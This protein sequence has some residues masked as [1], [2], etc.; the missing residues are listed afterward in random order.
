MTTNTD[1]P[2]IYRGLTIGIVGVL[3][4]AI[5]PI[6]L[7]RLYETGRIS[8]EGIGIAICIEFIAMALG[9]MIGAKVLSQGHM[10]VRLTLV[11]VA[12]AAANVW[13]PVATGNLIL[14]SRA[15]AGLFGGMM[16]WVVLTTILRTHTPE[17]WSGI[18]LSGHTAVQ[19]AA[20]TVIAVLI[21]PQFGAAGGY[22]LL[23]AISLALIPIAIVMPNIRPITNNRTETNA[24]SIP[25]VGWLLLAS[26]MLLNAMFS[27][28][29]SY[30]EVEFQSRGFSVDETL[31]I[32]PV[33]L[34]AQIVGGIC[35]AI[36]AARSPQTFVVVAVSAALVVAIWWLS[37]P[38]DVT[39][40]YIGF[41][42]YGFCWL[43]VGPFQ[44]GILLRKSF[45]PQTG[46]L[47]AAAQLL[48][49]A[50]GP[51][52]A[53]SVL[54]EGGYPPATYHYAL[55]GASVVILA[56]ALILR[57]KPAAVLSHT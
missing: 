43:F 14:V 56:V 28:V 11:C 15:L 51:L 49:L 55:I 21:V 19:F 20:A 2:P 42:L 39:Q 41:A 1:T 29:I 12:L 57:N 38:L 26:I 47:L 8:A 34:L 53:A 37:T 6:L 36:F 45:A 16:I 10:T 5:A 25:L 40:A 4:V 48:G 23:A 24:S 3:A 18:Y 17:K 27:S 9:S 54:L 52:M 44:L 32:V 7:T 13:T 46:E 30:A 22:L 50:F 31:A 33:I 35:A